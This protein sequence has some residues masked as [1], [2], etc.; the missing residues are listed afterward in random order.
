MDTVA[1]PFLPTESFGHRYFG[2]IL[3]YLSVSLPIR[4]KGSRV[5]LRVP[6]LVRQQLGVDDA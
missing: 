1:I 3:Y 6:S 5:V 4:L 2:Q